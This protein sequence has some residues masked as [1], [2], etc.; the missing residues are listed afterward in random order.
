MNITLT[1]ND[2]V[3]RML[4]TFSGTGYEM[5]ECNIDKLKKHSLISFNKLGSAQDFSDNW[6]KNFS[7]TYTINKSTSSDASY[8]PIIIKNSSSKIDF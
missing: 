8:I 5:D 3:G 7:R 6:P 1:P 2:T 4:Y